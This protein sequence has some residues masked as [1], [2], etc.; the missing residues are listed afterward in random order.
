MFRTNTLIKTYSP[1]LNR[2]LSKKYSLSTLNLSEQDISAFENRINIKFNQK[3]II[4]QAL[5]HP[6]YNHSHFEANERLEWLG[7]RI[8][9]LYTAEFLITKFPKLLPEE[10]QDLQQI[11]Y[12]EKNL[13]KFSFT[14][15]MNQLIRWTPITSDFNHKAPVGQSKVFGKAVQALVGAIYNDQGAAVARAF[16][17][18]NLLSSDIDETKVKHLDQPK[19]R[20]LALAKLNNFSEIKY[21]VAYETNKFTPVTMY[22]VFLFIGSKKIGEGSGNSISNAQSKAAKHALISHFKNYSRDF[23]FTA[24]IEDSEDQITFMPLN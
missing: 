15:G 21:S 1:S 8:I 13:A 16:V 6:S 23:D 19:R 18:K 24:T 4:S 5:T 22:T 10:L 12:G 7:K 14:W 2:V 20:L 17:E 11:Y 9:N 3:Q